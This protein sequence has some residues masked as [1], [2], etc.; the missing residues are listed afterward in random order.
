MFMSSAK[1]TEI[2]RYDARTA[3]GRNQD[4]E[5]R[6]GNGRE[7]I[8]PGPP[9]TPPRTPSNEVISLFA[10][11]TK[12]T[13][14]PVIFMHCWKLLCGAKISHEEWDTIQFKYDEKL[15]ELLLLVEDQNQPGWN[16]EEKYACDTHVEGHFFEV[17][18]PKKNEGPKKFR[19]AAQGLATPQA[20]PN[21]ITREEDDLSND[22]SDQEEEKR[23]D[24]GRDAPNA[25]TM[26]YR[27]IR[28][29]GPGRNLEAVNEMTQNLLTPPIT[30]EHVNGEFTLT[31]TQVVPTMESG[32]AKTEDKAP[33]NRNAR[34]KSHDCVQHQW[35][36]GVGEDGC[37][38]ADATAGAAAKYQYYGNNAQIQADE[39]FAKETEA[40]DVRA[41]EQL[42]MARKKEEDAS[43]AKAE[44][45]Q[46]KEEA[47]KQRAA[48]KREKER[49]AQIDED[50]LIARAHEQ[51]EKEATELRKKE[52]ETVPKVKG[53]PGQ[54]S[55]TVR[56]PVRQG[57][58]RTVAEV[59]PTPS[60]ESCL[61]DSAHGY[62]S[63]VVNLYRNQ[64][65]S[66]HTGTQMGRISEMRTELML[67]LSESVGANDGYVSQHQAKKSIMHQFQ[68]K[69]EG[70]DITWT[71]YTSAITREIMVALR[72][73]TDRNGRV[74]IGYLISTLD[75]QYRTDYEQEWYQAIM[76]A[77]IT[78]LTAI[79]RSMDAPEPTMRGA[80]RG[81]PGPGGN[82]TPGS[83]GSRG[84]QHD[85]GT[86]SK[87]SPNV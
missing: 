4:M 57:D 25:S 8:N 34:D 9:T 72:L 64:F 10:L 1:R 13:K 30:R 59:T 37:S 6:Q 77:L 45:L 55:F 32:P 33:K 41:K 78:L 56:A 23:E 3:G 85:G 18:V 44:K 49:Q 81:G 21:E 80:P 38:W 75:A 19:D 50:E 83:Q 15:V 82:G 74:M 62:V 71:E 35:T 24:A 39:K 67:K 2:P 28:N 7:V 48:A 70:S 27:N 53:K 65:E 79:N 46:K 84:P 69:V 73:A 43:Q 14:N 36:G 52:E 29:G 26:D 54:K 51:N 61:R 40:A 31:R 17:N 16:W 11:N 47:K 42:A 63:H 5:G 86:Y 68:A 12:E 22:S 58:K 66:T 20:V 87:N 60:A 76:H